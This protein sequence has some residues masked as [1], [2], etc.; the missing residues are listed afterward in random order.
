MSTQHH[1]YHARFTPPLPTRRYP[2]LGDHVFVGWL[3]LAERPLPEM[4]SFSLRRREADLQTV[5][6]VTV[7]PLSAAQGQSIPPEALRIAEAFDTALRRWVCTRPRQGFSDVAATLLSEFGVRFL[8][9]L[10]VLPAA[11]DEPDGLLVPPDQCVNAALGPSHWAV[12]GE[13][14]QQQPAHEASHGAC[15]ICRHQ[16]PSTA[17]ATTPSRVRSVLLAGTAGLA[18]GSGRRCGRD[19]RAEPAGA[20]AHDKAGDHHRSGGGGGGG[21]DDRRSRAADDGRTRCRP[22]RDRAGGLCSMQGCS[23]VAV[24]VCGRRGGSERSRRRPC[25]PSAATTAGMCDARTQSSLGHGAA[26]LRSVVAPS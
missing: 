12:L 22:G 6:S 17:R 11:P 25:A 13:L 14:L 7:E 4:A 9:A 2:H 1:L 24:V 8:P 16:P 3:L 19:A 18:G 23:V 15:S 20:A 21:R 5:H 10:A 26:D